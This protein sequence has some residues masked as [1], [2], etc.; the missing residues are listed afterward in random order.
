V[1]SLST[2]G[3]G[4][5]FYHGSD[6]NLGGDF[7]VTMIQVLA[8]V[9][10][11]AAIE[12][13]PALGKPEILRDL[14]D[15]LLNRSAAVISHKLTMGLLGSPPDRWA[16]LLPQSDISPSKPK[17]IPDFEFVFAGYVG[18]M[19]A[20]TLPS[21]ITAKLVPVIMGLFNMPKEKVDF[22]VKKFLPAV[23]ESLS[24]FHIELLDRVALLRRLISFG[25]K[26]LFAF[27]FQE[28]Y[29]AID[30]FLRK[31]VNFV[32]GLLLP[33]V[34][35]LGDVLSGD[36][37]WEKGIPLGLNVYPGDERCRLHQP[38]AKWHEMSASAFLE[39]SYMS[40]KLN[41]LTSRQSSSGSGMF[42]P[43]EEGAAVFTAAQLTSWTK[44][45]RSLMSAS[46]VTSYAEA[47]VNEVTAIY[48]AIDANM[49]GTASYSELLLK[50][51]DLDAHDQ[52]HFS[53]PEP[54]VERILQAA[55][56]QTSLVV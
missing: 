53:G 33:A 32:G 15:V 13:L 6:T 41:K 44:Q 56:Q 39:L 40:D 1:E 12:H 28:T 5:A 14:S 46:S 48:N 8:Y 25:M 55:Q 27:S 43:N 3:F 24:H 31:D 42:D 52:L 37:W 50:L 29:F 18:T 2:L 47:L 36:I 17:D 35:I 49:D 10:H 54:F 11:Q 45:T 19:L 26:I 51:N 4:S 21:P 20:A 22:I 16:A 34:N 23:T 38:H 7:D 9:G 30:F